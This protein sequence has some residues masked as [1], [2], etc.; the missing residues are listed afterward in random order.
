MLKEKE[1]LINQ[2]N[3][4]IQDLLKSEK[5]DQV[6]YFEN[7]KSDL[8]TAKSNIMLH[9][10][11]NDISK[12]APIAQYANF[13]AK[14]ERELYKLIRYANIYLDSLSTSCNNDIEGLV[15]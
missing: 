14:E 3:L 1:D 9:D 13:N 12:V 6:K 7:K 15:P 5:N 11:L 4:L 8:I 2:M 10:V